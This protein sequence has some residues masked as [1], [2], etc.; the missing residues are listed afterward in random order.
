MTRPEPVDC[1]LCGRPNADD[2]VMVEWAQPHDSP[3]EGQAKIRFEVV[4]RCRDRAG[5]RARVDAARKPWPIIDA[6]PAPTRALA[7]VR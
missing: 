5:C 2:R 4:D 3:F 1:R 7:S 6:T